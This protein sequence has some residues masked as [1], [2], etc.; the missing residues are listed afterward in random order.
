M[1]ILQKKTISMIK[2]VIYLVVF[3]LNF[4]EINAQ[5]AIPALSPLASVEQNLGLA[6]IKIG[7]GRPSLKGRKMIGDLSI[8]FGKVWRLGANE[9]TTITVDADILIEG[10][11]LAKGKY[12]LLAIPDVNEWTIIV[13]SND[14]LWGA[15]NYN[16]TKDV[17]R[18]KVPFEKL[19]Q[20][21][22]TLLFV[23][24]DITP[25]AASLVLMWENV[26]LKIKVSHD[27]DE[28]IM[29][30]IKEKTSKDNPNIA[31]L[32]YA[33]EY[34]L[35]KNRDLETALGWASKVVDKRKSPFVLNLKAHIAQKLGKCDLAI[36]A[37]KGAIEETKKNNDVAAKTEAENIIKTC[38]TK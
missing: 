36:E 35:L 26:K 3:I 12:A 38:Q 7:Y 24:D 28:K 20:N 11:T 33:A 18:F 22:E 23:F 37:A 15:Y 21:I 30:D 8:P 2:I 1:N 13:N 17:L 19:S 9:V 29:V 27:P 14:K 5:I 4:S 31:T 32:M 34:Y 25:T 6:T 16:E 10:K